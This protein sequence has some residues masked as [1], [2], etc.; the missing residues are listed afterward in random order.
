M[1]L[2]G[3][4]GAL[5]VVFFYGFGA[6]YSLVRVLGVA[7]NGVSTHFL[8]KAAAAAAAAA[9]P[10]TAAAAAAVVAGPQLLS[11]E[12]LTTTFDG[13]I[14]FSEFDQKSM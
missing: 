9:A 2:F 1:S 7:I 5:L 11:R 13:K 14:C 8:Q 10:A 12:K 4:F 3:R 6:R